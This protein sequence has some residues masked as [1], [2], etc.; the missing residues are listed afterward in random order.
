MEKP[1]G[2]AAADHARKYSSEGQTPGNPLATATTTNG[3]L[4]MGGCWMGS[5]PMELSNCTAFCA[6]DCADLNF[7]KAKSQSRTS[8][9]REKRTLADFRSLVSL[10]R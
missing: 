1:V 5:I 4:L 10:H 6:L 8:R 7:A 9:W 2:I 3:G